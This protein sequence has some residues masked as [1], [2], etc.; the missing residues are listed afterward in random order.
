MSEM[1]L[2]IENW[3]RFSRE[4]D[5]LEEGWKENLLALVALLSAGTANASDWE[6][7]VPP[8][9]IEA[10]GIDDYSSTSVDLRDATQDG[11][12]TKKEFSD[13]LD[14]VNTVGEAEALSSKTHE[15]MNWVRDHPDVY[16]TMKTLNAEPAPQARIGTTGGLTSDDVLTQFESG[17][18]PSPPETQMLKALSTDDSKPDL[19]KRAQ[20]ILN[21]L[22]K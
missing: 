14:Q 7:P 13:L 17:V 11:K 10:V 8:E 20:E 16:D 2:I 12:L 19:A 21:N 5:I 3:R 6:I 18:I 15:L 9:A 22:D 4:E 1:K